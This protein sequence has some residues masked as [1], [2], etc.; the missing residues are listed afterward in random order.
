MRL[1][2]DII[3]TVLTYANDGVIRLL[4]K[5]CLIRRKI[6]LNINRLS[7]RLLKNHTPFRIKRD[8]SYYPINQEWLQGLEMIRWRTYEW[9]ITRKTVG[10][11]AP[12]H[13]RSVILDDGE[14][15]LLPRKIVIRGIGF[16]PNEVGVVRPNGYKR[17]H[18]HQKMRRP[19]TK[20]R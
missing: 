5:T 8:R 11:T 10:H 18:V 15:I 12:W 20:G 17:P 4:F 9:F 14:V 1:D 16:A 2:N 6:N 7:F 13:Y 19:P 3:L